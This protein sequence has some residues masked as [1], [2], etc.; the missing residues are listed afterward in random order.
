[1]P[2]YDSG[3]RYDSGARYAAAGP[4]PDPITRKPMKKVKLDLAGRSDLEIVALADAHVK[5]VADHAVTFPSPAPDVADFAL[6]ITAANTALANIT[7]ADQALTAA[8]Q[9]AKEKIA[10]LKDGLDTRAGYVATIAKTTPTAIALAA[11]DQASTNTTPLGLPAQPQN[12]RVSHGPLPG[13]MQL[14][15]APVKGAKSYIWECRKHVD[16]EA[17]VQIKVSTAA[18]YLAEGLI[19]GVEYAFR[20]RAVG[21]AG[22]GPWSDEAVLRAV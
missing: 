2:S 8:R 22:D 21:A 1:M 15:C 12:F 13:T 3:V 11:F 5:A 20:V 16:G 10:L 4:T 19:A 7:V 18:N 14:R 9:Q 17:W 6:L